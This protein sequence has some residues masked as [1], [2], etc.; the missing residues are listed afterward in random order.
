MV[1]TPYAK[2]VCDSD[3]GD[4]GIYFYE[5]YFTWIRRDGVASLKINYEDIKEIKRTYSLKKRV[6][7]C[8]KDG[9]FVNFYLYKADTLIKFLT[10]AV[11]KKEVKESNSNSLPNKA[12]QEDDLD[13][14]ERISKLH[15]SGA[16]T[17]EEFEKMKSKI[18]G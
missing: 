10:D 6:T 9:K 8:L 4:G 5:D 7:V 16:L 3:K 17:D 18:I 14:L 2:M 1:E 12:V 11:Q 15:D 13:K